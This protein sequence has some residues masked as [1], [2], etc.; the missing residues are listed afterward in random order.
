ML[1]S[2][3]LATIGLAALAVSVSASGIA[4]G[5]ARGVATTSSS[6]ELDNFWPT[7]AVAACPT[8]FT[9]TEVIYITMPS[10]SLSEDYSYQGAAAAPTDADTG[11]V[12]SPTATSQAQSS[13]D[14]GN[15]SNPTNAPPAA[16]VPSNSPNTEMPSAAATDPDT[17]SSASPIEASSPAPATETTK[18]STTA[19]PTI[20]PTPMA[21]ALTAAPAATKAPKAAVTK[22][23]AAAAAPAPSPNNAPE[24]AVT[25]ASA[26][27]EKASL[28]QTFGIE[29]LPDANV[30]VMHVS[31][32]TNSTDGAA[33]MTL[34]FGALGA[35]S[36]K[37]ST[38]TVTT[39]ATVATSTSTA[40]MTWT[41]GTAVGD[42]KTWAEAETTTPS[43]T[44]EK[45]GV[46]L[47]Q[48]GAVTVGLSVAPSTWSSS[49]SS[50][51]LSV[52]STAKASSSRAS[53]TS[54]SS[55][56][57][58]SSSNDDGDVTE[59]VMADDMPVIWHQ[60]N[61]TRTLPH[62]EISTLQTLYSAADT[63][64]AL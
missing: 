26:T 51:S 56:S 59:D 46:K 64:S 54:S 44:A 55:S 25:T 13:A 31:T 36:N 37:A 45:S 62:S 58:S 47:V 21:P 50:S 43:T 53:P 2:T 5:N 12:A 19:E 23:P 60:Q 18:P 11:V 8:A 49:L 30:T 35:I 40:P 10:P 41:A 22:A 14:D 28:D 4:S 33:P 29:D 9:T 16:S 42:K 27:P 7:S 32:S 52:V 63:T 15:A 20:S 1:S 17:I 34:D 6:T 61:A 24:V 3:T 48:T 38:A 57:S 39:T